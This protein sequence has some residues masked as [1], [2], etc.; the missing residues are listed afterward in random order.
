M[1]I[2]YFAS[3][4]YEDALKVFTDVLSIWQNI[5]GDESYEMT[6]VL[7]NIGCTYFVLNKLSAALEVMSEALEIQR[8][9]L[10]ENVV[11]KVNCSKQIAA[12]VNLSLL[13][14][15][16]TMC[17]MAHLFFFMKSMEEVRFLLDQ[18]VLIHKTLF[19]GQCTKELLRLEQILTSM[20]SDKPRSPVH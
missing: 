12:A 14:V 6:R 13:G 10:I 20:I 11:K 19:R 4:Q 17:N 7:N 5:D 1:G 15:S 18:A 9:F 3:E 2:A 16:E 8:S